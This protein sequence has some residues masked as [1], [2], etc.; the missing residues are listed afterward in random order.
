VHASVL[1]TSVK[2]R[3]CSSLD[4]TILGVGE[5]GS[6]KSFDEARV[7]QLVCAN[8]YIYI[9]YQYTPHAVSA[10]AAVEENSGAGRLVFSCQADLVWFFKNEAAKQR[11]NNAGGDKRSMRALKRKEMTTKPNVCELPRNNNMYT[12]SSSP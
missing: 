7:R 1:S 3:V 4:C 12:L 8:T 9:H 5:E 10:S 11:N 2:A 6:K